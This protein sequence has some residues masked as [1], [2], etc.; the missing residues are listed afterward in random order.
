MAEKNKN[1]KNRE[2]EIQNI[3]ITDESLTGRAGLTFIARYLGNIGILPVIAE[4]FE[5]VRKSR[6]GKDV[7]KIV[8]QMICYA[9]DGTK[10]TMTRFDELSD[11]PGY[12][13]AIETARNDAVSSHAM[14]RFF[15]SEEAWM[16]PKLQKVM[17]K[18][19]IWK[20]KQDKPEKIVLGA[21]TMVLD[22]ND[23]ERR[24]GVSWT[25]KKVKGCHPLFIYWERYAVNMVFHKGK[26][27]TNRQNDFFQ[28]LQDTIA[29]IRSEYRKDVP[30]I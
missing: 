11:D 22:N 12:L 16:L 1:R 4:A 3:G 29:A 27:Q 7:E 18:L 14:K 17:L 19:F 15:S 23:V 25:Y 2:N 30:I 21:D 26:D 28:A 9:I 8:S 24:E 13:Q 6:K 20:L 5:G 10:Q